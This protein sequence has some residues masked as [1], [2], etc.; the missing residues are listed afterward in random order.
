MGGGGIRRFGGNNTGSRGFR[1][2]SS[3][4]GDEEARMGDMTGGFVDPMRCP[5]IEVTMEDMDGVRGGGGIR[6]FVIRS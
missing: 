1:T 4:S 5:N 3:G 6:R 2:G